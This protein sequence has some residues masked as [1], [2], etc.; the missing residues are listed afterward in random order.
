MTQIPPVQIQYE[1]ICFS[2]FLSHFWNA[3]LRSLAL[4]IH[5]I[6]TYLLI[7]LNVLTLVS[8][9]WWLSPHL[10]LC[11]LNLAPWLYT[12]PVPV[13][14]AILAFSVSTIS[15]APT[16]SIFLD[17]AGPPTWA[18]LREGKEVERHQEIF[19]KDKEREMESHFIY[20]CVKDSFKIYSIVLNSPYIEANCDSNSKF[21]SH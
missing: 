14:L 2:L 6:F 1:R 4:I 8:W 18:I 3:F 9:P 5:N 10:H 11:L 13:P 12:S 16:A 19:Y 17:L 15:L 21:T 7:T 20:F